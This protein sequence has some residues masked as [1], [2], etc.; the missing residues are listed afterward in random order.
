MAYVLLCSP[1]SANVQTLP[2]D[3]LLT[4]LTTEVMGRVDHLVEAIHERYKDRYFEGE[5]MS[6]SYDL[7]RF[8]LTISCDSGVLVD[9]QG[10]KFSARVM[11]VFPPKN[12]IS[13]LSSPSLKTSPSLKRKRAVSAASDT[14]S[15]LSHTPGSDATVP[16]HILGG[17]LNI[18]LKES[19]V[20]DDP[21]KYFYKVQILEEEK[22]HKDSNPQDKDFYVP[23]GRRESGRVKEREREKEVANGVEGNDSRAK[24]SGSLMEVQ[25][26]AMS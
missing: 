4:Y 23:N 6:L 16:V 11:Q 25:C 9:V 26:N 24:W 21:A 22:T 2:N 17:D 15:S 8:C 12:L 5:S 14:S 18:T 19:V 20:R 1:T 7:F 13:T 3:Q 10:D